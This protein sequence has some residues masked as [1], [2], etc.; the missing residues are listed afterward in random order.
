MK[1][2]ASFLFAPIILLTTACSSHY[3]VSNHGHGHGHRSNHVSV[4]VHG[5]SH[6][7]AGS[8]L[9]ALIVGGVI[10]HILTEEANN[11]DKHSENNQRQVNKRMSSEDELVNGYPIESKSTSKL[12]KNDEQNRFYQLGKDGKCY[13]MEKARNGTVDIVSMVPEFSCR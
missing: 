1:L 5:S 11:D 6:G 13:L 8:V 4:G 7:N 9:G 3:A 10:G 2:S 12:E